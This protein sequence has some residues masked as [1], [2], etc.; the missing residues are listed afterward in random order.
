[1][2]AGPTSPDFGLIAPPLADGVSTN[3]GAPLAFNSV[4]AAIPCAKVTGSKLVAG[5]ATVPRS[6]SETQPMRVYGA[7]TLT[8]DQWDAVTLR[9][10]AIVAGGLVPGAVY[11]QWSAGKMNEGAAF[12][13][14]GDIKWVVGVALSETTLLV[15]PRRHAIAN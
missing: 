7:V 6:D 9:G 5:I 11:V 13:S 2:S 1:M 15:Y 8:T 3:S 12:M 14:N 4:G 10:G